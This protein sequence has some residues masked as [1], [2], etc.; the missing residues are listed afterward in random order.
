MFFRAATKIKC[1][2]NISNWILLKF[3]RLS[4]II[5]QYNAAKKTHLIIENHC[6]TRYL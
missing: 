6:I 5:V 4:S 3:G 2:K 1:A